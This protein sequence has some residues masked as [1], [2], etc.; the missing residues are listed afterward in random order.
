MVGHRDAGDADVDRAQR[1]VDAG[2]TLEDEGVPLICDH[3]SRIHATSCQEG[4]GVV[5]HS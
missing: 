5:I 1:V 2:D 4:G 3:C